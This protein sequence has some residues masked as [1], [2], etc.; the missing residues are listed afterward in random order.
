MNKNI[1]VCAVSK[2]I[3]SKQI[4]RRT[5]HVA[6]HVIVRILEALS[7]SLIHEGAMVV[8]LNV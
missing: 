5:L 6:T 7:D 8:F 3:A 1:C 2:K 4:G